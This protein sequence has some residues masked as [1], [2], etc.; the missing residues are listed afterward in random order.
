MAGVNELE[1]MVIKE[2][3]D[4][5]TLES[6]KRAVEIGLWKSED[7]L[8]SK[9]FKKGSSVLD[10][11]CGTGRTTLQ[12]AKKGYKVTGIDITPAM[13]EAAKKIASSKKMKIEYR[14]GDATKLDFQDESFD[15]A[16]F[17][18][19]GMMQIPGEANRNKAIREAYRVIRPGGYFI[20]TT[21]S[22]TYGVDAR[23]L[24]WLKRWVEY[25]VLRPFGYETEGVDFGDIFFERHDK[26]QEAQKQFIHIP[27]ADHIIN[28]AN[29][30][31][32]ELVYNEMRSKIAAVDNKLQ[33]A[34]CMMY[35]CRKP[36]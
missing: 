17:S 11:G 9:Y 29:K 1:G 14:V 24:N 2:F 7:L 12:L 36:K 21:H 6:Y 30:T 20:F 33:S 4:K 28:V 25:E 5:K 16:L 3:S 32:F 10:I 22:R 27:R 23:T 18:F 34:D 26:T 13:I 8:I 15:N 19:N 31:G 35:V